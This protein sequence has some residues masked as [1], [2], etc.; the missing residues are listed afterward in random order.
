MS[1][2]SRP[3]PHCPKC[4]AVV[5]LGTADSR[6]KCW[7]FCSEACR[8]ADFLGWIHEEYKISSPITEDDLYKAEDFEAPEQDEED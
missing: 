4:G 3:E 2:Q 8:N 6:P 7:P 1:P 5:A